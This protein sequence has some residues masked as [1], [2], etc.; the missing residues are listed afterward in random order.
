MIL[1]QKHSFTFPKHI[2]P[3][4]NSSFRSHRVYI[5]R[6]TEM[7]IST[8]ISQTLTN[9]IHRYGSRYH[10]D[11][12]ANSLSS[13]PIILAPL[14]SCNQC[15]RDGLPTFCCL[16]A[17]ILVPPRCC[18]RCH[19]NEVLPYHC[20]SVAPRCFVL[21]P[22]K[23]PKFISFAQVGLTENSFG[24]TELGQKCVT[25]GFLCGGYI[26][27]S[28]PSYPVREPSEHAYTSTIHFLR[29]NHLLMC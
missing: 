9:Q 14:S 22:P 12:L 24:A 8:A 15:H 11:G 13:V 21:V 6:A 4:P 26:Y 7:I 28:T 16:V 25:V 1:L 19:R 20:T 3:K 18:N 17:I 2:Y 5:F 27:P 10:R 23:R 29:E